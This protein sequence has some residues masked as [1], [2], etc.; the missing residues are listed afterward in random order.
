MLAS[1]RSMKSHVWPWS[2]CAEGTW[3][4]AGDA[5][6]EP[7]LISPQVF[8]DTEHNLQLGAKD[9]LSLTPSPSTLSHILTHADTH[10]KGISITN[11]RKKMMMTNN[12]AFQGQKY[13]NGVGAVP[14]RMMGSAPDV[15]SLQMARRTLSTVSSWSVQEHSASQRTVLLLSGNN[16]TV[17][18]PCCIRRDVTQPTTRRHRL[19][20]QQQ[21]IIIVCE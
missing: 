2:Q 13:T 21:G 7:H 6:Y 1:P 16:I 4:D 8:H 11:E 18:A 17:R 5:W 12:Y 14:Q 9:S 3:A 19:L 20:C 15:C 10:K